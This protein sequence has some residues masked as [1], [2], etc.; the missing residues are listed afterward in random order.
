MIT[1]P[2]SSKRLKDMVPVKEL[3]VAPVHT[4]DK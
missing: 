2:V 4:N 3:R 1:Q